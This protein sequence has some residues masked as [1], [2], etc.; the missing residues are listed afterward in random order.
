[1]PQIDRTG[2]V[3][4]RWSGGQLD[5]RAPRD[6]LATEELSGRAGGGLRVVV[7]EEHVGIVAGVR[8]RRLG[9]LMHAGCRPNF[10]LAIESV[11]S[12]GW[13]STAASASDGRRGQ[14]AGLDAFV[15]RRS[16]R[17]VA[18]ERLGEIWVIS[19]IS[20]RKWMRRIVKDNCHWRKSGRIPTAEDPSWGW[21]TRQA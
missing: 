11:P 8:C 17:S 7:R 1:M 21:P 16:G 12:L 18:P 5:L 2:G 20:A 10:D 19:G 14:V 13:S 9:E 4:G 3:W 15:R 6:L